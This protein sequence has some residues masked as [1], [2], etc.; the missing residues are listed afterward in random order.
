MHALRM[1]AALIFAFALAGCGGG[2]EE[3]LMPDVVGQ[4]LDVAQSD[5][6][7]A[8]FGDDVEVVG[9]GVFGVVD[10]SNWTVCEQLPAAGAAVT[11]T[12]RLVVDRS[13]DGGDA[14]DDADA[15]PS[16]EPEAP[17]PEAAPYSYTGPLYE[18]V[19]ADDGITPAEL[20]QYWVYT[21]ELD[22]ST[23]AYKDQ[24]RAII[25]DIAHQQNTDKFLVDVVTDEEIAQAEASSTMES[26]V[27]EHGID[28][29]Q[30]TIPDK[31]RSGW[32]ASYVGGFDGD[33]LEA[34]DTAYEVVWMIASDH[35]EFEQWKPEVAG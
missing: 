17:E 32:V 5:I 4:Q 12:P 20:T 7:R 35:P 26:F 1:T 27:D 6:E 13:C 25:S 2:D 3:T 29:F 18:I 15:A 33:T 10:E 21:G 34:S 30:Q 28:Y 23:D 19:V 22:L 9:G 8:G 16:D 24:V 11:D 31:E 14:A